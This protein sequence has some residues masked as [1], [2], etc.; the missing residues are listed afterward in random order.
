MSYLTFILDPI[1]AVF[2]AVYSYVPAVLGVVVTLVVGGLVARGAGKL[3]T[4]FLKDIHVDRM[5]NTLG[6][7]HVLTAGGIKR[8]VSDLVGYVISWA[9]AIAVL[10]T[11]LKIAGI[12]VL[13]DTVDHIVGYI[14]NVYA[15]VLALTF[16]MIIAHIVAVFIRMVATNTDMPKPET[17]AT[18]SKW[19]IVFMAI[20]Q[21]I[22]KI[23]LGYC[24]TG[25]PLLMLFG[26]F[27]LALG[28]SFGIGG[29]DT[30]SRYLDRLLK[31]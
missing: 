20:G 26:A 4:K 9:I 22:D 31:K 25:T 8:S 23:G 19:A 17:L 30:A 18:L 7:D 6:V 13:T 24:L 28:L 12:T 5:S 2:G 16:G 21:F 11:T 27:C 29:R 3:I 15:G 10:V 1:K 14:P